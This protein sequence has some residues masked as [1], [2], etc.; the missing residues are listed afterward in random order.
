MTLGLLGCIRREINHMQFFYWV[1]LLMVIGIAIFAF[2]NVTAPLIMIKFLLWKFETS[3]LY[4]ILGSIVAGILITLFFWVPRAIK[5]SIRSKELKKK[6]ANLETM[7]YGPPPS[8]GEG[9][10]PKEL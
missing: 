2:Q 8:K 1:I 10:K 6:I 7:L 3:L 5:A 4:T 9:D